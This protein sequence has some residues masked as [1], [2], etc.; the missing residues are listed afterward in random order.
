[1]IDAATGGHVWAD[2]FDSELADVFALQDRVTAQIV[3][4]LQLAL[5]PEES[6]AIS[7][8]A[9]SIPAAHDAYLQARSY[10]ERRTIED[11]REA[12]HWLDKALELDPDYADALGARAWLVLEAGERYWLDRIGLKQG[13][14][15]MAKAAQAALARPSPLAHVVAAELLLKKPDPDAAWEEVQNGLA[16]DPNE[17]GFHVLAGIV[18][19]GRGEFGLA[20]AAIDTAFKLNPRYPVHFLQARGQVHHLE[21]DLEDALKFYSRALDTNPDNWTPLVLRS[22]VL[23]ELGRTKDA[24]ADLEIVRS[25]HEENRAQAQFTATALAWFW[26]RGFNFDF[27]A[28][29][30]KTL[31]QIGAPEFPKESYARTENQMTREEILREIT[32]T[33]SIG[34]CCG[35]TWMVDTFE[36]SSQTQYW[37]DQVV[38]RRQRLVLPNGDARYIKEDKFVPDEVC[39]QYRDP[40][41]SDETYDGHIAVCNHGVFPYGVFPLPE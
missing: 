11:F 2:R 34:H 14:A 25:K 16:L 20:H 35:G 41:G 28:R 13:Y 21:G 1:M 10:L 26:G 40:D 38:T 23:S 6:A 15:T 37:N 30:K 5:T 7:K 18:H 22:A 17:A 27:V 9:T 24:K 3:E 12:R 29:L 31:Q 36:D 8:V 4:N 19:A 39:R 33:R 32:N